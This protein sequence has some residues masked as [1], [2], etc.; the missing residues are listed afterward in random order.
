MAPKPMPGFVFILVTY[1]F[2]TR[3]LTSLVA[4]LTLILRMRGSS[5]AAVV[6]FS[7]KMR[8]AAAALLSPAFFVIICQNASMCMYV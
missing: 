6:D 7:G 1:H 5:R 4:R 3:C 2:H 8:S